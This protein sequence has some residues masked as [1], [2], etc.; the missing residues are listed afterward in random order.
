MS[1]KEKILL[2]MG[3]V[4]L[5]VAIGVVTLPL[6][7]IVLNTFIVKK[8]DIGI[9]TMISFGWGPIAGMIIGAVIGI[10]TALLI[11]SRYKK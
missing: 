6:L 5:V 9:L 10:I 11:L 2:I 3:L 1:K 7:L 8:G 4:I